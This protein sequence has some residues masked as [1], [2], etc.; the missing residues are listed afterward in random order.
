M[1]CFSWICK[2]CGK[3]IKSNSFS[4]EE[5]KLFLLKDGK[6]IQKMEGQYDSYGRVFIAG[7]RD[8]ETAKYHD[9]PVPESAEWSDPFPE[10]PKEGA[11][12]DNWGRVCEL[13][14]A[15]RYGLVK[16]DEEA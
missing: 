6:V 8:M 5:C 1:G 12:E 13:L 14:S 3:G 9:I 2:E 10:R 16:N 11:R 7:T 15:N 4:G